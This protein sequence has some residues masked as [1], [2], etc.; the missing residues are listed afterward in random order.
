MQWE[1]IE[2]RD[3]IRFSWNVW[4]STKQESQ[5]FVVPVACTYTP[6]KEIANLSVLGYE[7]VKCKCNGVLNPYCPYDIR[8][9]TWTCPLCSQR[10]PLPPNYAEIS[11]ENLPPELRFENTTVEYVLPRSIVIPPIFLFVVDTCM[12]RSEL[13]ALKETLVYTINTLP[14][15]SLVGLITFGA[16]V[17]VHELGYEH[18][19]KSYVFRGSRNYTSEMI[20]EMLSLSS[21]SSGAARRFISR[22]DE[23]EF[24]LSTI[25]EQI[26]VDPWPVASGKRPQRCTGT[27]L[28]IAVSLLENTFPNTGARIMT[29]ASGPCTSG[30]GA[31]VAVESSELMRTHLDIEKEKAPFLSKASKFYKELAKRAATNGHVV[32]V[33]VGYLDQIGMMEMSHMVNLTGGHFVLADTFDMMLFKQSFKKIF[34]TDSYG[35]MEM[36]LNGMLEVEVSRD[37]K[38]CGMIGT[39]QASRPKN[40][41]VSD[42][43]IGCSGTTGWKVCG[44]DPHTTH[45]IYF[46]VQNQSDVGTSHG[47]APRGYVQLSTRY[48][49]SS[50]QLRLRVTTACR[51]ISLSND[52]SITQSFDQEAAAVVMARIAVFKTS[53]DDSGDILRWVDKMLIRLC[54]RFADF[55]K[56]DANSFRLPENFILY[57]QF[58]YHLRRSQFLQVFNSSPDETAYVRHLLNSEN[59]LNSLIMIQPTLMSYSLSNLEGEPVLLDSMSLKNDCILLLDTFFQ[60]LVYHGETVA[61]W[62]N[63][64][65]QDQSGYEAFKVMLENPNKDAKEIFKDRFPLPRFA[66]CDHGGSQARF[67]LSKL[68]PSNTHLSGYADGMTPSGTATVFTEDV[69]FQVFMEHLK[70]IVVTTTQ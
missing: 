57:P 45:A 69:S 70:K 31:V 28:S 67:L 54:L 68:N 66:V 62:R 36:G 18:L 21:S 47:G 23:C 25:L 19:P 24:Q 14:Q 37:L 9:R 32:D 4:P 40:A 35:Y 6:L 12:E 46:E 13:D 39:G 22:L 63:A 26:T 3:G 30:D 59:T 2:E 1:S 10:N 16:M 64:G 11:P 65:Y 52:A 61:G 49:H 27:A 20:K 17:H 43:E 58:M 38:V 48:Q 51:N 8:S 53:Q 60:V 34:R 29:F 7:P 15:D 50:G 42:L 55:R 44:I 56:D 41:S 5:K 33:L